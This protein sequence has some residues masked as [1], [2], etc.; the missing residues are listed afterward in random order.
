MNSVRLPAV[1]IPEMETGNLLPLLHEI[2]HALERLLAS[3]EGTVID[4]RALPMAPGEEQRLERAL[5]EGEV[6]ATLD[7]LGR[8]VIRET[9]Y[10][11]VWHITH[12]NADDEVLGKYVEIARVPGLIE[13]QQE[14][15]QEAL[16]ELQQKLNSSPSG[17][18]TS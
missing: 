4:L 16:A 8:S 6:Q 7:A 15:M 10:S 14:A 18:S 2:R 5:G 17:E 13:A 11:G 12:Y 1:E 3:G 9:R